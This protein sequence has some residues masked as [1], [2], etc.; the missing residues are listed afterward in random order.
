M[1]DRPAYYAR[2][3]YT[4]RVMLWPELA[5]AVEMH[6]ALGSPIVL[7]NGCFDLLH[8]GHLLKLAQVR[9]SKADY[10]IVSVDTDFQVYLIKAR[11]AALNQWDRAAMV[12]ALPGVDA[13][14]FHGGGDSG[15]PAL[16]RLLRPDRW[17]RRE[18][19][20][21]NEDAAAQAVGCEIV[22]TG[23]N[24]DWSSTTLRSR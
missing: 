7:T 15:L 8:P 6:R 23:R 9:R 4:E 11:H 1:D 19:A 13:V 22:R 17:H 10:V 12:A 14:T 2:L 3:S 24:G 16:M 20:P 5:E 18:D 21:V